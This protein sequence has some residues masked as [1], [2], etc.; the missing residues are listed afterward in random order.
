LKFRRNLDRIA[1]GEAGVGGAA[2][3]YLIETHMHV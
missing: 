3:L 2:R 1:V